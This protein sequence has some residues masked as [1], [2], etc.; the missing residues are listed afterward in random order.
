MWPNGTGVFFVPKSVGQISVQIWVQL[1]PKNPCGQALTDSWT[2]ML[3]LLLV[4]VLVLLVLLA[5]VLVLVLVLA[6]ITMHV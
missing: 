1:L 3:L 4:L 5:L 2:T 6:G